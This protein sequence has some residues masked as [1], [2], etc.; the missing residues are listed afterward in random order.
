MFALLT[1][2]PPSTNQVLIPAKQSE[3][4]GQ[5]LD[6]QKYQACTSG[7]EGLGGI[8]AG[9]ITLDVEGL[10]LSTGGALDVDGLLLSSLGLPVVDRAIVSDILRFFASHGCLT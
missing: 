5:S 1:S 6:L 8:G 2:F 9:V 7:V 3:A 4:T 10:L